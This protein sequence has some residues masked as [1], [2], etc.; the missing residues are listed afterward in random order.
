MSSFIPSPKHFNSIEK[1]LHKL[2][3]SSNF[4]G[5]SELQ[6]HFLYLHG[7][8]YNAPVYLKHAEISGIIDTLRIL[9]ATCVTLQYKHHYEGKLNSEIKEET[10]YLLNNKDEHTI[11]SY[12]GL[13]NALRCVRYQIELQHLEELRPLSGDECC[14]MFFL[15][16]LIP[17]IADY[18]LDQ[19]PE[20]KTCQWHIE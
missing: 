11:L 8:A 10:D 3:S 15:N 19:L 13:Y 6:S 12:H 9:S 14:A 17:C 2:Y 18:S 5:P 16:V 20:D 1:T 4:F 7:N